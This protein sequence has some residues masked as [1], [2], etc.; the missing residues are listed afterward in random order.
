MNEKEATNNSICVVIPVW[1]DAAVL[2][3]TLPVLLREWPAGAIWVVDGGSG[4]APGDVAKCHGV[5]FLQVEAPSRARQMNA[6]AAAC[7]GD[8]ILFLHADTH[9]PK[10]SRLRIAEEISRGAIGGAFARRFDTRALFLRTTCR[11]ADWRGK[12]FGVY[13]GDQGI[14]A[15][16]EA[17]A[18]LGGFPD[19]PF[20]EDFEFTRRL[21]RLG[22]TVLLHPPVLSSGRRF[23]AKGPVRQTFADVAL[24]IRYLLRGAAIFREPKESLSSIGVGIS[25]Q[26]NVSR[27]SRRGRRVGALA[28]GNVEVADPHPGILVFLKAPVPGRVKTRLAR[29]LGEE[30]ACGIYRQMVERQLAALPSGWPVEIH[31]S[32][33]S[34]YPDFAA[35]LGS[36]YHY[37]PQ[38]E[39]D[40]GR[41]LR[42]AAAAAFGRGHGN[43]ILIGG[44]CPALHAEDLEET[45]RLLSIRADMVIGPAT[46]GGYYL[47]GLRARADSLLLF[48]QIPWST[49]DVTRLTMERANALGLEIARLEE[50]EDVDDLPAYRRAIA[51]KQLKA[52]EAIF[53]TKRTEGDPVRPRSNRN[54]FGLDE[55]DFERG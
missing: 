5:R 23:R 24:T 55:K 47:L 37:H 4:D 49:P 54:E 46:D 45:K 41:R 13:L 15:T 30:A 51:K 34:A 14:F 20:F 26:R 48:E 17:F 42:S 27:A 10:N 21:S 38:P 11:A 52:P 44:D 8:V 18:K 31:F 35:W 22:R 1:N 7:G 32:P 53:L 6:G 2:E 16:R 43:I 12:W 9:L 29:D 39:G 50:K 33:A 3:R 40:L 25:P 36:G 28:N 19:Q